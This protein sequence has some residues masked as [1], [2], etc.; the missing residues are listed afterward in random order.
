MRNF[1][2]ERLVMDFFESMGPSL[3]N[4]LDAYERF[5]D[6][7]AIWKNSGFP[8]MV[9]I[10]A[11]KALLV[12]QKRLFDFER[13]RVLEHRLLTSA[14]DAVFFER[15]D[16]IVNSADEVV[17]AFDILGVFLIRGG[18]IVEWRDY[19]DTSVLKQDWATKNPDRFQ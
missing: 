3:Q 17:Y 12:E 6:P 7:K 5:M 1:E 2:N 8:D 13:V 19:M 9:G 18:R 14:D 16:S 15:R 10:E 4:V 11:M